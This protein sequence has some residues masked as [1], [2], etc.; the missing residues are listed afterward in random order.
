MSE[1]TPGWYWHRAD[2]PPDRI[3]A[4]WEIVRVTEHRWVLWAGNE[5]GMALDEC[6]GP[7]IGPITGPHE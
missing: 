7:F 1:L 2:Y 4:G 3:E 6:S 5:W